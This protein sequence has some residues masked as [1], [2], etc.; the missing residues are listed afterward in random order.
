MTIQTSPTLR[1]AA[2][3]LSIIAALGI[4]PGPAALAQGAS[5]TV[6]PVGPIPAGPSTLTVT[7]Q[8]FDPA[9]NGV[10]VVFGP[11][12]PAPGYY[13]DPS[14]YGAFKW[15]HPGA[16]ES[17]AEAPLGT[18]G[19][20]STTLDVT[21]TFTSSAGDIDCSVSACAV[22]TF[23]AHGSPDRTQDTCSA[24]SFVAAA[25]ESEAPVASAQASASAQPMGSTG[26]MT[27]AAPSAG[28]PC[29]IIGAP[30]S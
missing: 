21:S 8:G 11:I 14:L 6:A 22:I 19:S 23:A 27:S 28:D 5:I 4:V 18:D 16:T 30:G 2:I 20:F 13:Q 7:G 25:V 12:T 17:A 29:A 15:V 3:G 24:V 9:G 26:P 1:R 10:Y